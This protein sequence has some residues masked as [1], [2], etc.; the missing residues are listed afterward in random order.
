MEWAFGRTDGFSVC[1]RPEGGENAGSPPLPTSQAPAETAAT[2][3]LP[4]ASPDAAG[5]RTA[6]TENSPWPVRESGV[7]FGRREQVSGMGDFVA[8]L[9][10]VD[11][12]YV[13]VRE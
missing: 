7:L 1:G 6:G 13:Y 11:Q 4:H 12:K 3:K 8:S 5:I 9:S 10:H 2:D